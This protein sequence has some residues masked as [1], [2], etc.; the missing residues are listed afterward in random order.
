MIFSRFVDVKMS[1]RFKSSNVRARLGNRQ[2]KLFQVGSDKAIAGI[3]DARIK[4][5]NKPT[6]ATDAR[7]FIKSGNSQDARQMIN[8][9]RRTDKFSPVS[10]NKSEN[11]KKFAIVSSKNEP[12]IK[13]NKGNNL[14]RTINNNGS[15]GSP[16][17]SKKFK[18][19]LAGKKVQSIQTSSSMLNINNTMRSDSS[20][21]NKSF[22][23]K[24]LVITTMSSPA[25]SNVKKKKKVPLP[26]MKTI[27]PIQFDEQ[28]LS[29]MKP[30]K[31][32]RN[33][34]PLKR[35]I[36]NEYEEVSPSKQIFSSSSFGDKSNLIIKTTNEHVK[37]QHSLFQRSNTYPSMQSSTIQDDDFSFIHGIVRNKS[38]KDSSKVILD[39][40]K[41]FDSTFITVNNVKPKT[42]ANKGSQ[43]VQIQTSNRNKVIQANNRAANSFKK[44]IVKASSTH[45]MS[46]QTETIEDDV[47]PFH[48]PVVNQDFHDTSSQ[49]CKIRIS[50]LAPSVTEEDVIELFGIIGNMKQAKLI[51]AGFA[52]VTYI[53]MSHAEEA[54]KQYHLREL[55]GQPMIVQIRDPPSTLSPQ[56]GQISVMDRLAPAHK[57]PSFQVDEEEIKRK[58]EEKKKKEE[59]RL[60]E[61]A[62]QQDEK[63]RLL[64]NKRK[65]EEE[66]QRQKKI[67]EQKEKLLQQQKKIQIEQEELKRQQEHLEK[68]AEERRKEAALLA[69]TAAA[70]VSGPL[71]LGKSQ[72][73][74][75]VDD[76]SDE[77]IDVSLIHKALFRSANNDTRNTAVSFTVK[78]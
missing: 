30:I 40:S 32:V 13:Q 41:S 8:A 21:T 3:S 74:V 48:H 61:Q 76:K 58:E 24:N 67:I 44:P 72:N 65:K 15:I 59:A 52:D 51:K 10:Y 53:K 47:I 43:S 75:A 60:Q 54:V 36:T 31:V 9:K 26:V 50:N 45:Q 6:I 14:S 23:S 25:T 46:M 11:E 17:K 68:L 78:I 77:I 66:L 7:K 16:V 5:Q 1:M 20:P 12:M 22:S 70:H 57:Y 18:K 29:T 38:S 19:Q 39:N 63:T 34:N 55:D 28:N 56:P 62:R 37:Q 2:N 35:S 42:K 73:P 33:S 4:L 69:A 27:T 49:R 64:E 71:K